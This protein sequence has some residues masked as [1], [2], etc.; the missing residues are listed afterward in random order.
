ML[1]ATLWAIPYHGEC[2][3]IEMS[4]NLGMTSQKVCDTLVASLM[5]DNESKCTCTTWA[6]ATQVDVVTPSCQIVQ[7]AAEHK[8]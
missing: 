1:P 5:V 4:D 3:S 8:K 7:I 2:A 6:Q